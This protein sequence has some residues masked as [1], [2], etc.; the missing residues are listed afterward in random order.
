MH[1]AAALANFALVC[2]RCGKSP[3]SLVSS[4]V[5]ENLEQTNMIMQSLRT[6][7]PKTERLSTAT[8]ASLGL[9]P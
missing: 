7:F 5:V 2:A 4:S 3:L 9:S 1:L 6:K 8:L